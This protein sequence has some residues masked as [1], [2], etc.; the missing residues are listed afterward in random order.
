[1]QSIRM[2]V[3]KTILFLCYERNIRLCQVLNKSVKNRIGKWLLFFCCFPYMLFRWL[4]VSFC[5]RTVGKRNVARQNLRERAQDFE[6]ELA[7][8]AIAKNE[9]FYIREWI[10]YYKAVGVTKIYLYDNESEDQLLDTVR[11]F[12]E[13]G[14]VVYNYFPGKSRQLEAYNDAVKKYGGT[15]RYMA[16]VDCDEFLVPTADR[17]LPE[18]VSELL[19]QVPNAGGL[20]VNWA[21]YGSSGF[22]KRQTGLITATYLQR[23]EDFAWQNFHVKTIVNPRLVKDYISPHFPL[24]VT[25]AWSVDSKGHRQRLWYNHDVDFGMIRCN[26]YF[27]KSR[28]EFAAKQSR[29]MADRQEKYD[30]HKFE[31]YDLNEKRDDNMLRYVEGIKR[32]L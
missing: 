15:A 3:F 23:G 14:T 4:F 1:M 25:G 10:A 29:G 6:D 19:L 27:C 2:G 32:F 24:Y 18:V 9:A 8:V 16:F 20:G 26:H 5:E 17:P 12:M 31:E 11:D 30:F 22:E 13:E 7:V 28:E 21:L